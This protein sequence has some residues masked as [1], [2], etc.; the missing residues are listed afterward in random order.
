MGGKRPD[1]Y[2]IDV[3]EGGATDYKTYPDFPNEAAL[4]RKRVSQNDKLAKG[5]PIPPTAP[6]P[7]AEKARAEWEERQAKKED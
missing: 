1:Q 7:E 5:Q 4:D 6:N 2:Q 3:D